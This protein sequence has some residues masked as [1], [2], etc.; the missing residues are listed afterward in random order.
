MIAITAAIP[1]DIII[2]ATSISIT[3]QQLHDEPSFFSSVSC[4][5]ESTVLICCSVEVLDSSTVDDGL[6][7][8]V[9][10]S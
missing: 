7:W 2:E 10:K 5:S 6:S 4:K 3:L 8:L 9:D 1:A